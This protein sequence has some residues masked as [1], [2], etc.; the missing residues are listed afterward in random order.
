[1]ERPCPECDE[2]GLE[3]IYGRPTSKTMD[4]AKRGEVVLGGCMIGKGMPQ[5]YCPKCEHR[6]GDA[7]APYEELLRKG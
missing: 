1:M 6:W 7:Y 2:Q 5:W 3:I 4:R